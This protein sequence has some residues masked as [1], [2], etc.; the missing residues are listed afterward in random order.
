MH[1]ISYICTNNVF[2]EKYKSRKKF[3][4]RKSIIVNNVSQIGLPE[5]MMLF[6]N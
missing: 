1:D 4:S 5:L 6:P 3:D 2:F